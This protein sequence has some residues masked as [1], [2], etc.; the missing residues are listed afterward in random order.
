VKPIL[1]F[2]MES[3]PHC[4]R[5]LLWMEELKQEKPE[6]RDLQITIIDETMHPDISSNYDYYYVPTYFVE[7]SKVHEGVPS[8]DLIRNVFNKAC[9]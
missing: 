8:K 5:A 1:M 4:K 9:E 3:C 2:T 7:N 6:Y